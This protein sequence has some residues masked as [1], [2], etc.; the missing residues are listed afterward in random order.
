[1]ADEEEVVLGDLVTEI[2]VRDFLGGIETVKSLHL[3]QWIKGLS[4]FVRR[5][6]DQP[7]ETQTFTETLDGTGETTIMLSYRP[8]LDLT[9]LEVD[10]DEVD[11]AD[12]LFYDHGEIYHE[13]GFPSGKQNVVVEYDA[14]NGETVPEDLRLAVMLI[15]EQA[16]QASLLMQA[17]R[18]EYSY[19]FAP[20]KWPADAREIID[21]YK[22]KR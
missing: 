7:I 22:R 12:V 1:M 6:I 17:T 13:D 20:T 4:A 5:Y 18:G 11:V 21:S 10:G 3:Q 19:V 2:E 8:V 9:S 14:G 15:L 16:S